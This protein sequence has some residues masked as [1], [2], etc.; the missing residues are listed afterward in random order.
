MTLKLEN[1]MV[2]AIEGNGDHHVGSG[3][4]CPKGRALP[5]LLSAPDRLRR[6]L[7]K[8]RS[9]AWEEI[10]W[11]QAY[12]ILTGRIDKLKKA[13]GPQALAVHVGQPGVGKEFL[14]Y[15]ERFC[16]LFGTPNFSTCG[17]HCYES[18][19]MA[20]V[21][22]FGAMPIA[23]Y[24][25]SQCIVL[26][27]KNPSS[28]A[29]SLVSE[30]AEA[31]QRGCALIVIDPRATPLAKE[32]DL[33]L[34]LR[35]GTDGALA[36]GLI[37]VIVKE[38]LYDKRFVDTWTLGFE[39]LRDSAAEYTPEVVE[40]ITWVPASRIREAARLYASTSPA[41]ISVGVALELSTNGFQAVRAIA[42]LQAIT[43]NVDV[44]GGAVFLKEAPLSDLSLKARHSGKQAIGAEKYPLFHA[45]TGHAQANL[46]AQAILEGKPYPLRGL[47]VAGSNPV[48]TWPHAVRVRQALATL[49][50]LAVI[51][52]FMTETAN[53]AHL[54]LP[55]AT[56]LGGHELWDS[57]HLSTEPRLGLAPRLANNEG[58]PTNWEIWKEIA[59]RMGHADFFPWNTEEEAI[60]FRLQLLNLTFEDLM[61]MPAGYAYHRWVERRHEK[62]C[63]ETASGKVEI[64]ST[65]L[66]RHGYDPLPAYTEPAESPV[67]TPGVAS[68]YPLVLTTGARRIEYLH[69]RFRNLPSLRRRAPE[70]YVEVNPLT[71]AD[72]QVQDGDLL[73]IET[74][75]GKI[76]V[77]ARC[78]ASILPN[79]ISLPHGWNEANANVLTDDEKLDPVTGFPGGRSL[80]ARLEKKD[81][82]VTGS[83]RTEEKEEQSMLRS[84][85]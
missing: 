24:G 76:E 48:L 67:S 69:S 61:E 56:F 49:E 20:N 79:V 4:L 21:L 85:G 14:P 40:R 84:F 45:S 80:L 30:I 57:S 47:I 12:E 42:I 36:L 74:P 50:F 26:W 65:E 53:L 25:R 55:C 15:V 63:F 34:Q 52:P 66:K 70:P 51:D 22:T 62:E 60:N 46:Y 59:T 41:C 43:G 39:E 10:S 9:G 33:H 78:T 31:R 54:V 27:G 29:P 73:V 72:L 82:V 81:R 13:H 71:A 64:Y 75:R 7:R 68:L 23:D 11:D 28:S 16:T 77:K 19:S 37:H 58:L 6:P 5:E 8:R 38:N 2:V 35:P 18:K 32:A 83:I 1:E 3:R 17:S 44:A